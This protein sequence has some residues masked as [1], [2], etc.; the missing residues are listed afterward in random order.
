MNSE[1][2]EL[3]KAT[4][5]AEFEACRGRN[6]VSAALLAE[7][8]VAAIAA[9]QEPERESPVCPNCGPL[10]PGTS[11][12]GCENPHPAPTPRTTA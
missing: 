7:K 5:Q 11:P 10:L 1:M 2:V 3:V 6:G 12:F 9:M 4:I 8:V